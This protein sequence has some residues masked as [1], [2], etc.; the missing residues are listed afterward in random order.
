MSGIFKEVVTLV[1]LSPENVLHE[2][3][4]RPKERLRIKP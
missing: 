3:L 4:E 2:Y 1:K